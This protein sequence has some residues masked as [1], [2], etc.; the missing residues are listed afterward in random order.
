MDLKILP[1]IQLSLLL[2]VEEGEGEGASDSGGGGSLQFFILMCD[3]LVHPVEEF[4][5][6]ITKCCLRVRPIFICFDAIFSEGLLH[7]CPQPPKDP[8]TFGLCVSTSFSE[9]EIPVRLSFAP[10]FGS[11]RATGRRSCR[12]YGMNPMAKATRR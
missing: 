8:L 3:G 2:A 12:V 1:V 11:A 10:D 7:W 5:L 9:H 6:F 4:I